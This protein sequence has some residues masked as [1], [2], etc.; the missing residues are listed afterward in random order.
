[1]KLVTFLATAI[2]ATTAY[3]STNIYHSFDRALRGIELQNACVSATE[4]STINPTNNCVKLVPVPPRCRGDNCD[5]GVQWVCKQWEKAHQVYSR[6]FT[7]T[8]CVEYSQPK[9]DNDT[10]YCLRT[11]EK[12]EF[13]PDTIKISVVTSRGDHGGNFPGVV[14]NF[15]FPSCK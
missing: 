7:R 13:L 2:M 5:G 1:M 3:A 10:M 15:T 11:I 8:V 6:S 12:P 14:Q 4:V 9:S